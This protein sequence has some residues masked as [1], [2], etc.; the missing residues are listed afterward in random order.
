MK[1]IAFLISLGLLISLYNTPTLAATDTF[2]I[3]IATNNEEMNSEATAETESAW[4]DDPE[5][6]KLKRESERLALEN[7]IFERE[8][9]RLLA[10]IEA[11]KN[12]VML[13]NELQELLI[14]QAELKT[15]LKMASPQYLKDPFINGQLIISDRRI[16]LNGPILSDTADYITENIHYLNNKD[17]DYPIFLVIERS[18]GGSVMEGARIIEA[19]KYSEAP[20]YIVVKSVAASMAAILTAQAKRSFAYPN[21][22]I[23]HHQISSFFYGNPTQVNQDLKMTQEWGERLMRPVAEKMGITLD[24]FTQLMYE[25][26]TEGNWTEFANRAKELGWVDHVVS[27]VRE[28]SYLKPPQSD[29]EESAEI[30]IDAVMMHDTEGQPYMKLPP[31]MLGD[32]YLLNNPNRFYRY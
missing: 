30:T 12:R 32:F 23:I 5:L 7:E 29:D 10:K 16:R 14:R 18:P 4:P 9:Q 3:K 15:E 24:E 26:N 28:T 21:A 1:S 8:Q 22:L 20:V 17:P 25:K 27:G 11:E 19:M 2:K 31:P 13:E 6:A